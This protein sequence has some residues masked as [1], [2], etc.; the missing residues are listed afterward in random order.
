MGSCTYV[1][2]RIPA[3]AHTHPHAMSKKLPNKK[4]VG[5]KK[6]RENVFPTYP[7]VIFPLFCILLC[8][9]K[10][11]EWKIEHP[12]THPPMSFRTT[13]L[14]CLPLNSWGRGQSICFAF[15]VWRCFCWIQD[16]A[17]LLSLQ[18]YEWCHRLVS[19]CVASME[20]SAA[21]V[22]L[23]NSFSSSCPRALSWS[24]VL[25]NWRRMCLSLNFLSLP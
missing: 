17:W 12:S 4:M 3:H 21:F 20:K 23:G 1:H 22:P 13:M 14:G 19:G 10:L 8:H 5:I 11:L 9:R 6:W 18:M 7:T 16:L 24:L 15:V 2:N 25:S